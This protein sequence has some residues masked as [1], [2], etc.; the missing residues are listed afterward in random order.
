MQK[1]STF[2]FVS[3]SATEE[4]K[5]PTSYRKTK[6][7]IFHQSERLSNSP[8]GMGSG[9][10]TSA[11]LELFSLP[12]VNLPCYWANIPRKEPYS[13]TARCI[14]W[15]TLSASA[16]ALQLHAKCAVFRGSDAVT[17]VVCLHSVAFGSQLG[18][19]RG[20]SK[21]SWRCSSALFSMQAEV[22]K[23]TVALSLPSWEVSEE[24]LSHPERN[25]RPSGGK[26]QPHTPNSETQ[27]NLLS[28]CSTNLTLVQQK[29]ICVVKEKTDQ[30]RKKVFMVRMW[31]SI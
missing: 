19:G 24:D 3:I 9:G 20:I 4:P 28:K 26:Q 29:H 7:W 17:E 5:H 1:K 18:G 8:G 21:W 14:A 27:I 11:Q 25:C 2:D 30:G 6:W 22:E 15:S 10:T 31:W 13:Q 16:E 12:S 23:Y